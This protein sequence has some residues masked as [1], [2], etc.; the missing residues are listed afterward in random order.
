MTP[1]DASSRGGL[2]LKGVPL[3]PGLG[4]GTA[5]LLPQAGGGLPVADRK[6]AADLGAEASRFAA[7]C[8]RA[9]AGLEQIRLAVGAAVG[10]AV[11]GILEAQ[12]LLLRDAVFLDL[13]SKRIHDKKL[14]AETAVSEVVGELDHAL[15]QVEDPYLRERS[16]DLRDIGQRVYL[17]LTAGVRQLDLPEAAILVAPE[18]APSVVATLDPRRVS[19][20]VTELG[21]K[22]SH[23]AI[24]LRSLGIPAVGAIPDVA[25]SVPA[26][27]PVLLDAIA[28]LVFVDPEDHVLREYARLEADLV[29]H[30]ALLAQEAS[31]PAVT[32]DGVAVRV[33]ANLGKAADTEAAVRGGADGV[34]L[35]RTEFAFDIR[36]RFPTEDEQAAILRGVAE[37]L[38]PKPV[39]VRL[40]DIGA[41]KTFPYFP[42]PAVA[43]PALHLRGTRLLLAH[44]EVLRT[45]L[46]AILRV[47]GHC[48]VS[49]LLP[50]V[51]GVEEVRAV[52]H[53]LAAAKAELAS[54]G[55]TFDDALLLGA[56]IEVP[57]AALVADDLAR[58]TDF[59]SLGTND[60]VQYLL[61]ADRDEPAMSGYYRALHPAVL[62][63]LRSVVLA[64]RR[65]GKEVTLCGEIA[66][67][68]FY[69]ELLLGLGLR[70]F[71]VAPR[72]LGV[73]RHEIRRASVR[74]ATALARRVSSL[75]TRDEIRA[76]L[77]RRWERCGGALG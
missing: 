49:V 18:L 73:V 17:E 9:A 69:T 10:T 13:V 44:P 62:R 22:A 6:P 8:R 14:S 48:S 39:V 1:F 33:A 29:A 61:A 21:A 68:P 74:T 4:R 37:R 71:S 51:G 63:T 65:A 7:A 31:R 67:D 34:G 43:N 72:Q 56:M 52:K 70:S 20:V 27:S 47:S 77:E 54:E 5:C 11:A 12:E 58:E 24:L 57:S 3:S 75:P 55:T 25:R 76:A 16:A 35:F 38:A 15:G 23:V 32:T 45:Q 41:E 46:R 19:G 42:L 40:L 2:V 26:G 53:S 36:G 50:M 30:D 66:A 28:G 59:L 60:L 64:A